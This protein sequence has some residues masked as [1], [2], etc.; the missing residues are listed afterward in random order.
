M[1]KAT[2]EFDWNQIS[3]SK[4]DLEKLLGH[5]VR[6]F[7]YPYGD[8]N[9]AID[10]MVQRAGYDSGEGIEANAYWRTN[11]LFNEPAISVSNVRTL[12]TFIARVKYGL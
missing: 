9:A 10:A 8:H 12:N 7:A 11:R 5:P 1:T 2:A 6:S 3:G 4:A